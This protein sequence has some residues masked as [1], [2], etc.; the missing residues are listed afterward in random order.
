M[1]TKFST[2]LLITLLFLVSIGVAFYYWRKHKALHSD[3]SVQSD[4]LRAVH[5]QLR[6]ERL[7]FIAL[8]EEYSRSKVAQRIKVVRRSK[9]RVVEEAVNKYREVETKDELDSVIY[10]DI[11]RFLS[12]ELD[13]A[14]EAALDSSLAVAFDSTADVGEKS[15]SVV[16]LISTCEGIS[17]ERDTL[18]RLY[19]E[20]SEDVVDL[21]GHL[22]K[23]DR[24]SDS[25]FKEHVAV[26]VEKEELKDK[27]K[28]GRY[29][30]YGSVS[31][32]VLFFL[33][34]LL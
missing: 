24:V 22:R 15:R 12:V 18:R 31:V 32:N 3:Y 9:G 2:C 19:I 1:K 23:E 29:L 21:G 34:L 11:D 30:L 13:T 16:K 6:E 28:K 27:N 5:E 4:S 17:G 10:E 20:C 14:L 8:T 7:S 26:I 25:L 33:L